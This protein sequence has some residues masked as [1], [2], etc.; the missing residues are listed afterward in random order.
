MDYN[1]TYRGSDEIYPSGIPD[2]LAA[3][4]FFYIVCDKEG[5]LIEV[6][7][8]NTSFV[9]SKE[10]AEQLI[11]N[12]ESWTHDDTIYE[13]NVSFLHACS[14]DSEMLLRLERHLVR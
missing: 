8:G 14:A 5:H 4:S 6:N 11:K 1:V 9:F 13:C 3:Y 7:N 2:T 12:N 10:R